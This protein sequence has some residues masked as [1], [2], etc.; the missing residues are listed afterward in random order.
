[1]LEVKSQSE[2]PKQIYPPRLVVEYATKP[3]G[4]RDDVDLS[5]IFKVEYSMET[6]D[7]WASIQIM[8]GFIFALAVVIFGIRMNNWQSRQRAN[9]DDPASAG[10]ILGFQFMIHA[11]M[12]VC[13]TFVL[14]FFSFIVMICFYWLI[15]FKLQNEVFLLL[16]SDNEWYGVTNEYYFFEVSFHAL[17]YC[18]SMYVFYVIIQQCRS[19]II[20]VDWEQA[21]RGKPLGHGVSM[22]RLTT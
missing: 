6:A 12:V 15:F 11:F 10:S 14:L 20:F 8:I 19:D 1:M 5:L 22:W 13:H 18:Q 16:P 4:D 21:R 2:D 7:F 9:S 3:R 17:F